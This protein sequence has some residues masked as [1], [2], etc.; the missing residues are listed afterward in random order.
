VAKT[1][2]GYVVKLPRASAAMLTI[3]PRAPA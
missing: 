1:S 3:A 2:R